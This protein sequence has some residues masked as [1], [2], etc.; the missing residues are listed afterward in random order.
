MENTDISTLPQTF[1]SPRESQITLSVL[2]R[3]SEANFGG[4]IHGGHILSLM[5]Q[6][7]YTCGSRHAQ[8]YCITA[9]V[10]TVNFLTPIHVGDIVTIKAQVNYTGKTSMMIGIRVE[11][12]KPTEKLSRHSN[13]SYFTMVAKDAQGNSRIV[14]GLILET[15]DDV[16]RFVRSH[17]RRQSQIERQQRF[18]SQNF[19]LSRQI[20][21]WCST[22]NAQLA[23]DLYK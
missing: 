14:P 2:M 22:Q 10:N 9:A 20:L 17:D 8:S 1:K 18:H 4:K 7:A 12:Q 23:E 21:D 11:A 15:K 3:P 19:A 5:D 16:R 13:T 6:A